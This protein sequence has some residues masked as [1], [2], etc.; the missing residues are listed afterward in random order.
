M[1]HKSIQSKNVNQIKLHISV[2]T[3][4]IAEK[5]GIKKGMAS[6]LLSEP[7]GFLED[8]GAPG[9]ALKNRLAGMFDY[10][11]FFA[12]KQNDI[13]KQFKRLKKHLLPKGYLWVSWP[14]SRQKETD[15]TMKKV[16]EIG[17]SYGL[18]ESKAISI[19]STWA[20]I[21]FTHPKE[22]KVY[23]DRSNYSKT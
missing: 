4:S 2:M 3:R 21:K 11:H 20:A 22:G 9:L 6:F 18:V 15:L 14:K 12:L 10:I 5:L 7:E 23:K 1:D 17:Y 13:H 19:D 16:I 8:V